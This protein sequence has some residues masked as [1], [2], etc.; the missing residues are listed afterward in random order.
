MDKKDNKTKLAKKLGISRGMLY[1]HHKRPKA[2]LEV[3]ALIEQTLETHKDYG[4][5]RIALEVGL[6]KKTYSQSHEQ[7]W[8]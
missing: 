7:V 2:D 8:H 4:H 6:N 3:K 5:K 1:Y